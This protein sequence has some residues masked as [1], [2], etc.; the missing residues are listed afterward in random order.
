MLTL[1]EPTDAAVYATIGAH[2]FF[3]LGGARMNREF[4]Q[5]RLIYA[6][7][8]AGQRAYLGETELTAFECR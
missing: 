6:V 7:G 8:D 1:G 3:D 2:Q 4:K 5:F